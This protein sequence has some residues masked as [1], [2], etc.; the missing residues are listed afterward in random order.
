MDNQPDKQDNPGALNS[1]EQPETTVEQAN[2]QSNQNQLAS[3]PLVSETGSESVVTTPDSNPPNKPSKKGVRRFVPKINIYFLGIVFI[4][5]IAII[6]VV[7]AFM[8]NKTNT[9]TP[10]INPQSLTQSQLN[11]LQG[12]NPTVGTTNQDLTIQ[13]N[14]TF[15]GSILVRSNLNVAGTIIV[16]GNLSLPGI[17]VSGTSNFGQVQAN[18]LNVAGD[19]NTNGNLTVQKNLTVNGTAN[20]GGAVSASQLTVQNLILGGDL[21][22][23][24]HL[25]STG[26]I[27]SKT[28]G[29]ALG[30]GGTSTVSGTDTA[31]TITLNTGTGTTTGCFITV[32]FTD[33]FG[34]TP[35]VVISPISPSGAAIEY[36]V[37]RSTTQFSV[38]T[39][40]AAPAS[41][42]LSYDYITIQ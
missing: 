34:S 25:V 42:S 11:E 35:I 19:V 8:K 36:Y 14:T 26:S 17:T 4:V 23:T 9:K 33:A 7:I 40:T 22:L 31:G 16:G 5:I 32:N 15:N 37:T 3:A 39:A 12:S 41:A 30:S 10:T 28:S 18:Q 21:Q 27:P 24:R 6:V 20:F 38:C 2:G 1:L 29:S 13:S